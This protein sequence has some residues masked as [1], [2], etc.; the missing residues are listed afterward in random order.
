MVGKRADRLQERVRT[1]GEVM[2]G[3]EVE[4]GV[5]QKGERGI[6]KEYVMRKEAEIS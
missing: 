6:N 4:E 5:V 3:S 2:D 1:E